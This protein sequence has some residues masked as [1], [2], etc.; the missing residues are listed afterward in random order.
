MYQ[1][2]LKPE[3]GN[4]DDE[5]NYLNVFVCCKPL[6]TQENYRP[7][8]GFSEVFAKCSIRVL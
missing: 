7:I 4:E 8:F 3:S 6:E 5:F 2:N 1:M